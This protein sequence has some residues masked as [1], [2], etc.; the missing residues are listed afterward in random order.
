MSV[1]IDPRDLYLYV[2]NY[3]AS[4]LNEYTISQ[5]TGQP[6]GLSTSTFS[7]HGRRAHLHRR[8]SG[9]WP[10]RLHHRSIGDYIQGGRLDPNTG[11]LASIQNAPYKSIGHATCVTAV[12]HGNHPI[13]TVPV[14]AGS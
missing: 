6:S 13:Q 7:T 5:A 10:L 1:T 14:T 4:T 8:R 3:N 11:V 9:L 12:P 2:S